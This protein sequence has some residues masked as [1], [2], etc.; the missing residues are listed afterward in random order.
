MRKE[1]A[2]RLCR[3]AFS[4]SEPRSVPQASVA[5]LFPLFFFYR[6]LSP[7]CE[8]ILNKLCPVCEKNLQKS[9]FKHIEYRNFY[10]DELIYGLNS[11]TL[12]VH[13][14]IKE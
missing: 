8:D 4:I 11:R 6:I 13:L 12:T 5:D 14:Q 7:A 3:T 2:V 1:K 10:S 9:Y